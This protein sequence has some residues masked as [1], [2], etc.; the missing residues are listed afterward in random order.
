M[1]NIWLYNHNFFFLLLVILNLNIN[2]L[3][4]FSKALFSLKPF[5]QIL[6]LL[7]AFS[8]VF[9]HALWTLQLRLDDLLYFSGHLPKY[10]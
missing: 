6:D 8:V 3:T 5:S 1:L 10:N 2:I 7:I 4:L 9:P